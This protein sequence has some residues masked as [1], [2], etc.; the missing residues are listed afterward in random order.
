MPCIVWVPC[1]PQLPLLSNVGEKRYTRDKA[2]SRPLCECVG[3]VPVD[4]ICG[5][6]L[7]VSHNPHRVSCCSRCF[8]QPCITAWTLAQHVQCPSCLTPNFTHHGDPSL[9]Q[10]VLHL[11]IFCTS[12]HKGC[13][14]Q[15]LMKD[16]QIHLTS[17]EGC[18]FSMVDCP[19]T[20]LG[21]TPHTVQR[22]DLSKHTADKYSTHMK[23]IV[24]RH[25]HISARLDLQQTKIS[26]LKATLLK[27][28]SRSLDEALSDTVPALWYVRKDGS[29]R[30]DMSLNGSRLHGLVVPWISLFFLDSPC[31]LLLCILPTL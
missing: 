3:E 8:C 17:E 27:N 25:K 28:R 6:C 23:I 26:E 2:S 29:K 4:L 13:T 10:R 7:L 22:K 15:G 30:S 9:S 12:R 11:P 5:I 24:E 18:F 19:L 21:C 16:L 14:W 1:P 20:D 31:S